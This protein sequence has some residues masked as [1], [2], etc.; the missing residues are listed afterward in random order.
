MASKIPIQQPY[1]KFDG[2]LSSNYVTWIQGYK[3][4][5]ESL[6]FSSEEM[7]LKFPTFLE[8]EAFARYQKYSKEVKV[9]WPELEKTFVQSFSNS[10]TSPYI[11]HTRWCARASGRACYVVRCFR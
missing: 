5:C 4:W 2:S 9:D 7:C 3:Y 8:A 11:E 6:G 10:A 1:E